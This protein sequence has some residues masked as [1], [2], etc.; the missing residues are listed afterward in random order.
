MGEL[1]SF[2]GVYDSFRPSIIAVL[3][4]SETHQQTQ[5]RWAAYFEQFTFVIEHKY[6]I[7]NKVA[8]ALSLE[9]AF[10]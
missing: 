5:A 8:N 4:E 10:W 3:Q 9:Q 6:G 7:L 2:E 1:S